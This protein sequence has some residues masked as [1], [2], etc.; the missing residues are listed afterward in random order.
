MIR[1]WTGLLVVVGLLVVGA[2]AAAA[3]APP[4]VEEF[5]AELAE[6]GARAGLEVELVNP[7]DAPNDS[8]LREI[9]SADEAMVWIRRVCNCAVELGLGLG[10]I[11]LRNQG[12]VIRVVGGAAREL[13]GLIR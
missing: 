9:E 7:D 2:P 5:A 6:V 11:R 10:E 3:Q 12:W 13:C 4:E 1:P 8:D